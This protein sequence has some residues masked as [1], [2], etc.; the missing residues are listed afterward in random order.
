MYIDTYI[1][2]VCSRYDTQRQRIRVR[3]CKTAPGFEFLGLL[4]NESFSGLH[5][6][7]PAAVT[8]TAPG[9]RHTAVTLKVVLR[10][11]HVIVYFPSSQQKTHVS[12]QHYKLP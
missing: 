10:M 6:P 3:I 7:S 9:Y 12:R 2:A 11:L 4:S 5:L 8:V 1:S